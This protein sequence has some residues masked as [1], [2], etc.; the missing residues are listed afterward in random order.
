M[1]YAQEQKIQVKLE[2]DHNDSIVIKRIKF[3]KNC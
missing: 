1:N 2:L 3:L